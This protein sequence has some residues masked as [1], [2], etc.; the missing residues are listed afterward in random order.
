MYLSLSI[1]LSVYMHTPHRDIYTHIHTCHRDIYTHSRD[2]H[3]T[4]NNSHIP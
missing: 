2:I 3:N 1:Y 4:E